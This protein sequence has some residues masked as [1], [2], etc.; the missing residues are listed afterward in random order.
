VVGLDSH[1][2]AG[3]FLVVL[4]AE[5]GNGVERRADSPIATKLM[6]FG[7]A[8]P[9]ASSSSQ[10]ARLSGATQLNA[11]ESIGYERMRSE[12][13]GLVRGLISIAS[14]VVRLLILVIKSP[15]GR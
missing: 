2:A 12:L 15:I 8:P 1:L 3:D 6:G 9:A 14:V 5:A 7:P 11:M 4:L 13:G 10:E